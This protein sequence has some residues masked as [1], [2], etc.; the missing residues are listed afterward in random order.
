MDTVAA[1]TKSVSQM[2]RKLEKTEKMTDGFATSLAEIDPNMENGAEGKAFVEKMYESRFFTPKE[3]EPVMPKTNPQC[4][5][6]VAGK[7][8]QIE[9][10]Q[11][12]IDEANSFRDFMAEI[13]CAAYVNALV[14]SEDGISQIVPGELDISIDLELSR[15]YG[16][17][18]EGGPLSQI[19]IADLR[20]SDSY[21]RAVQTG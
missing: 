5:N 6:Q 1:Y 17:F 10:I 20:A 4:L 2:E 13:Y 3:T 14:T 21:D 19:Y 9:N 7:V 8:I 16:P 12:D 15:L 11:E 18:S